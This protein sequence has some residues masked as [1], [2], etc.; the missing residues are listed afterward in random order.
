M[1]L[2]SR[3]IRHLSL[4]LAVGSLAIGLL[5]SGSGTASADTLLIQSIDAAQ[6]TAADRPRR[7]RSMKDVEARFGTP[8]TRSAAV[9]KPPIT[10]WDYPD[11][12][13]YFEYDHVID[14]VRR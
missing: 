14:A 7:G 6:A 2:P 4:A 9:G 3:L 8:T 5:V 12:V 1:A 11:F 13:V 10:R